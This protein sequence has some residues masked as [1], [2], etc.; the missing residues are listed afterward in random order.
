VAENKNEKFT[1]EEP[2]ALPEDEVESARI[3]VREGLVEEAKKTLYKVLAYKPDFRPALEILK[4][5]EAIELKE[6]F[7]ESPLGSSRKKNPVME[8]ID[9]LIESLD[10][11]LGLGLNADVASPDANQEI[12]NAVVDS[13]SADLDS[14]ARFDLGVAFYEMGCYADALRELYRAEKKIRIEQT[15]LGKTGLAVASLISQCLVQVGRAYEA[16]AYLEPILT[17]PD[18]KHEDKLVLYYSMGLT[19]QAL[20]HPKNAIGWFQKISET[21]SDFRDVQIRLRQL[22]KT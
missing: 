11:D 3:L 15:F 2:K 9:S 13:N 5:I 21:D 20:G 17:E 8:D 10:R 1:L 12:W 6:L 14:Q 4:Q 19:E 22:T 7:R 16:K 18:L